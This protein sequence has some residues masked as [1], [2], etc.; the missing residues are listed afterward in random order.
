[1]LVELQ[2]DKFAC[3]K[4]FFTRGL[5][6]VLGDVDGANS[7]GKSTFLY[8]ID[9]CFG[10]TNFISR[11][12]YAI[13]DLGNH[14][15]DFAFTFRGKTFYF[16]RDTDNFKSVHICSASYERESEITLV[17][18]LEI[19]KNNYISKDAEST[20]RSMFSLHVRIWGGDNAVDVEKVLHLVSNQKG[21]VA[22]NELFKRF[23][24][25]EP[26]R[27]VAEREKELLRIKS[28]INGA[29]K[30]RVINKITK[31]KYEE[32][33]KDI[34]LTKLQINELEKSLQSKNT[35]IPDIVSKEV[36][37]HKLHRDKLQQVRNSMLLKLRR[38]ESDLSE[39]KYVDSESFRSIVKFFPEV[40]SERLANIESFHGKIGSIMK[41]ELGAQNRKLKKAITS[42]EEEISE[43]DQKIVSIVKN[44]DKPIAVIEHITKLATTLRDLELVCKT[45]LKYKDAVEELDNVKNQKVD[46]RDEVSQGV[47]IACN[48]AIAT[49][50]ENITPDQKSPELKIDGDK[51]EY[52][53]DKDSGAGK[54][55]L[56]VIEFDLAQLKIT[57]LPAVIH[58]SVLFKNISNESMERLIKYYNSDTSHQIFSSIDDWGKYSK[59]VVEV[60]KGTECLSLNEA[61]SLYGIDWR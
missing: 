44:V 42:I 48:S 15:F 24:S 27:E 13:S 10:G 21:L 37:S 25:Y 61:S 3:D 49:I 14:Q 41:S 51:Y 2:C 43:T 39:H 47:M 1:M 53:T 54:S 22:I 23:N 58:D 34:D 7:I 9:F 59:E 52:S 16:S 36:V 11:S 4:V 32:S 55:Y 17:Q 8:A 18:Y 50:S 6:V 31:K 28:G 46:L 5:N 35:S 30:A 56:S 29:Y 26:L 45:Y 33:L 60:L 19:L 12:S 38:V 40:N 20:F 57:A